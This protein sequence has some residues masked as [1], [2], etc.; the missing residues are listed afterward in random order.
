[1]ENWIQR[2]WVLQY[3][4]LRIFTVNNGGFTL[5]FLG[6]EGRRRSCWKSFYNLVLFIPNC[7]EIS[8]LYNK[9]WDLTCYVFR[10]F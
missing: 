7:D 6:G 3:G 10:K 1:M 2:Y 4:I 5:A 9:L 8:F